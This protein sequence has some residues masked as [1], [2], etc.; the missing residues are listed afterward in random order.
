MRERSAS[1]DEVAASADSEDALVMVWENGAARQEWAP[2]QA[3]ARAN[4]ARL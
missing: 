3:R 1:L 4:A 2:A